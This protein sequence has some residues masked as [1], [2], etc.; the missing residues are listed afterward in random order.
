MSIA[1]ERLPTE[2][3]SRR[4]GRARHGP[5]RPCR[6]RRCATF[7]GRL[8][9]AFTDTMVYAPAGLA[10]GQ[11]KNSVTQTANGTYMHLSASGDMGLLIDKV[12]E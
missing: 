10:V 8:G 5:S 3:C 11:V 12:R 1:A 6:R 7:R 4:A 2:W 9:L